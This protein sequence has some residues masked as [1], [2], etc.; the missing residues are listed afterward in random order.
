[1]HIWTIVHSCCYYYVQ[2]PTFCIDLLNLIF[3]MIISYIGHA[4]LVTIFHAATVVI[5]KLTWLLECSRVI[6]VSPKPC[7]HK[8]E[9]LVRCTI[10]YRG[11]HICHSIC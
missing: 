6:T 10:L 7:L 1:M 5:I 9:V 2:L 11:S 3:T 4:N 8:D